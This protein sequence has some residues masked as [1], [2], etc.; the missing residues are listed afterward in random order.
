MDKFDSSSLPPLSSPDFEEFSK[1]LETFDPTTQRIT[2]IQ[3]EHLFFPKIEAITADRKDA[4]KG[5]LDP[6]RINNFFA[7]IF[8]KNMGSIAQHAGTFFRLKTYWQKGNEDASGR[9]KQLLH[10]EVD[11][12][13]K[14]ASIGSVVSETATSTASSTT[15]DLKH[16]HAA[17]LKEPADLHEV[18][19]KSTRELS[20]QSEFNLGR[21]LFASEHNKDRTILCQKGVTIKAHSV[22]LDLQDWFRGA[23]QTKMRM[24]GTPKAISD[25]PEL[26]PNTVILDQFSEATIRHML[27]F[28]YMGDLPD[29]NLQ[30]LMDLYE[31]AHTIQS[32]SLMKTCFEVFVSTSNQFTMTGCIQFLGNLTSQPISVQRNFGEPV[33]RKFLELAGQA[34]PK[35]KIL[36]DT[37][38]AVTNTIIDALIASIPIVTPPDQKVLKEMLTQY[39][40]RGIKPIANSTELPY[41]LFI[42]E[43]LVYPYLKQYGAHLAQCH[44]AL[45][46][47]LRTDC[48]AETPGIALRN[49]LALCRAAEQLHDHRLKMAFLHLLAKCANTPLYTDYLREYLNL[50]ASAQHRDLEELITRQVILRGFVYIMNLRF[51]EL[52]DLPESFFNTSWGKTLRAL[53]LFNRNTHS[54]LRRDLLIEAAPSYPLAGILKAI[55]LPRVIEE[56]HLY[57]NY[58]G[59]LEELD[60][61]EASIEIVNQQHHLSNQILNDELL[62]SLQPLLIH[63]QDGIAY[64]VFS[65]YTSSPKEAMMKHEEARARGYFRAWCRH[66]L[67]SQ[68]PEEQFACFQEAAHLGDYSAMI[69]L[70]RCYID[71]IGVSSRTQEERKK[72]LDEAAKWCRRVLQ[73]FPNYITATQLLARITNIKE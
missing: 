30:Q 62:S 56:T 64:E 32:E 9:I 8:L 25:D 59:T 7:A 35:A 53:W 66:G 58:P 22:V 17:P 36:Q 68:I 33:C 23:N 61:T 16:I 31:L 39:F 43:L 70:A 6:Q 2:I 37:S 10:A 50:P 19:S 3:K 51:P 12:L 13:Q 4:E 65:N 27:Q 15:T 34:G 57:V 69:F 26:D 21:Q 48:I 46:I 5:K 60:D 45:D 40:V 52:S 72:N 63:D 44:A 14:I 49:C 54:G 73:L 55:L 42:T 67:R 11:L 24:Q 29:L 47:A 38:T 28:F 41:L 71:N 20:K 1:K 18:F